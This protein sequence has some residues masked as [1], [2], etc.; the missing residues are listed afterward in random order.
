MASEDESGRVVGGADG[1]YDGVL[2]VFVVEGG[3]MPLRLAPRGGCDICGG[4]G[5]GRLGTAVGAGA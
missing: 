3:G 5:C 4:Y 2:V 1:W